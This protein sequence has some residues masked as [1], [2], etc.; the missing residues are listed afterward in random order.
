MQAPSIDRELHEVS[1][2]LDLLKH[3]FYQRWVAGDLTRE[4]LAYY[5]GQYA[6]V[7]R[8]IPHWLEGTAS[9]DHAHSDALLSHAAEESDHVLLWDR[10]AAALGIDAATLLATP[11][12]AATAALIA[13]GDELV[14]KG[15]GAAAVW[16]TGAQQETLVVLKR[17]SEQPADRNR[18]TP[19][20]PG[21]WY[22]D[23]R[24]RHELRWWTGSEWSDRVS[25]A[26]RDGVDPV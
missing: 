8:A 11:A 14:D 23:P 21:A 16:S 26:G 19:A 18:P 7:V 5:T 2:R 3:P 6:H 13:R 25:D 1:E 10:F 24:A 9:R 22:P 4:E 15:H 12:N 20:A 17:P